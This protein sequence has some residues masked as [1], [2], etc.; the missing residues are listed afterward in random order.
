MNFT[1]FFCAT[2][3]DGLCK[4]HETLHL[5]KV[6]LVQDFSSY[7]SSTPSS[8]LTYPSLFHQITEDKN[9]SCSLSEAGVVELNVE[10]MFSWRDS[11]VSCHTQAA[12]TNTTCLQRAAGRGPKPSLT[13]TELRPAALVV[14]YPHITQNHHKSNKRVYL[15]C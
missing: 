5:K 1:L 13:A 2:R 8:Q 3:P 10:E 12:Q 11:A 15:A 14:V 6:Q 7:S 9:T 4:H